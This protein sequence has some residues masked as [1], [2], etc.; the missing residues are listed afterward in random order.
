MDQDSQVPPPLPRIQF[1][2]WT[3]FSLVTLCAFGSA[4]V[5]WIG[6][7]GVFD[8]ILLVLV[9]ALMAMGLALVAWLIVIF[10]TRVMAHLLDV[11]M[12]PF[13]YR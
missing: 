1:S 12:R 4:V 6:V 7:D 13:F 10:F 11:I 8:L 9:I 2:L 3:L 5:H